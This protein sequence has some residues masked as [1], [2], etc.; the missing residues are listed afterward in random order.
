[1]ILKWIGFVYF[2]CGLGIVLIF[3]EYFGFVVDDFVKFVWF[4]F[5]IVFVYYGDGY[6]WI[7]LVY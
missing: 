3:E 2:G 1:M 5:V 7:G 6:V 4:C